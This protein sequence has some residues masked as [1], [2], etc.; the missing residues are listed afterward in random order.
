M[1]SETAN[2]IAEVIASTL[3]G[4]A[5]N[6]IANNNIRFTTAAIINTMHHPLPLLDRAPLTPDGPD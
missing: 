2:H 6:L 3:Y 5:L 1:K 4:P